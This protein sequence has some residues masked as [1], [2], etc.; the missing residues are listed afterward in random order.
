MAVFGVAYL[1][2]PHL[3][4]WNAW[5]HCKKTAV[6]GSNSDLCENVCQ[7]FLAVFCPLS[8]LI[9]FTQSP[10]HSQYQHHLF[11]KFLSTC[12]SIQIT[13]NSGSESRLSQQLSLFIKLFSILKSK[14]SWAFCEF[15]FHHPIFNALK[16]PPSVFQNLNSTVM[17]AQVRISKYAARLKV[18]I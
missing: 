17:S 15:C 7:A 4:L 10:L 5:K 3:S 16:T 2:N 11:R 6:G 14:M 18:N 1:Y 8:I 9:E 13:F 12:S